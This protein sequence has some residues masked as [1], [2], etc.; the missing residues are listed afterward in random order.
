[1]AWVMTTTT[2]TTTTA[3]MTC[4]FGYDLVRPARDGSDRASG[5]GEMH[6]RRRS[7]GGKFE[8]LLSMRGESRRV[9]VRG[10][11]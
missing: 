2:R 10:E 8:L 5:A 4:N 9:V 3:T 7:K 6:K 1:M 11:I